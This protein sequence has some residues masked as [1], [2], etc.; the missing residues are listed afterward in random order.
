MAKKRYYQGSHD[1]MDESKGMKR[2][3]GEGHYDGYY[4]RRR[5][6][7]MDGGMIHEDKSAIANLPQDVK[8][9]QYPR[10]G[11]GYSDG[12]LNDTA[13]GIQDQVVADDRM[14]MKHLKPEKY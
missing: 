5:Q 4:E 12:R 7:K 9:M 14:M 8:Y 13:S 11:E 3:L 6:E 10:Y 2:R 1:R